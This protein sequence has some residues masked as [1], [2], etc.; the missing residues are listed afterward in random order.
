[1]TVA[2]TQTAVVGAEA[3]AETLHGG[4]RWAVRCYL[5]MLRW[6]L[7]ELRQVLP[8]MVMM[9]ILIGAGTVVGFGF[10]LGDAPQSAILFLATGATV[11]PLLTVGLVF[12]PSNV[13]EKK[14]RGTYDY[15]FSLP[16][17]RI[18][19]AL[20]TLTL[21]AIVAL[22]SIFVTLGVAALRFDL[23]LS[24]SPLVVPA[25]FA[26]ILMAGAIGIAIG[27]ALSDPRLT[28]LLTNLLVFGFL[29]F[30]PINYPPERLPGWMQSLHD[31]LPF[32]A[33]GQVMR[34]TLTDGLVDDLVRPFILLAVWGLA[35]LAVAYAVMIRRR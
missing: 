19:M 34:G 6:D 10:F 18:S 24:I 16:V 33:S 11:M 30:S 20:S 27:H 28:N 21:A 29:L 17:A 1:M 32:E 7:E 4:L 22:P 15:M 26:V 35:S 8:I 31:W 12:L 25:A 13:G 2:A 23:D 9:Q 3:P 5:L 14:L